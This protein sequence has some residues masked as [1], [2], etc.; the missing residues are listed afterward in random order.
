M[1]VKSLKKSLV[2]KVNIVEL[3]GSQI[4]VTM[5]LHQE[6][7]EVRESETLE[8]IFGLEKPEYREG[9]DFCARGVVAGFKKDEK[10]FRMIVSLWGFLVVVFPRDEKLFEGFTPTQDIYLCLKKV[11]S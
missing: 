10:G 11:E 3:E 6:I 2:P 7:F 1:K 9:V 4:S 8:F 5:D